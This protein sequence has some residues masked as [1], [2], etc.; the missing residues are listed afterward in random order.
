MNPAVIKLAKFVRDL[1]VLPETAILIGREN[2]DRDDFD[3]PIIVIDDSS[4]AAR[5]SRLESYD[6]ENE[7]MTYVVRR[8]HTC[9]LSFY[10]VDAVTRALDF[11]LLSASQTATELMATH[12]LEVSGFRDL[13]DVKSLTGASYSGRADLTVTV[14]NCTSAAV[15]TKRIDTLES[16]IWTENNEP[17][18]V[19]TT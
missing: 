3:D 19:V 10:G 6:G 8:R 1:L 5:I 11:E 14:T 9:V 17:I 2:E 12:A 4:P 16:E 13:I 15:P 7:E 18:P